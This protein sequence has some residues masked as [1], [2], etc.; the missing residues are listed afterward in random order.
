MDAL[1][2]QRNFREVV[3][4]LPDGVVIT[5][6]RGVIQYVNRA[7]LGLFGRTSRSL[8]GKDFGFPMVSGDTTE[9]DILKQGSAAIVVEM[10]IVNISWRGESALLATLR[11][12]SKRILLSRELKRSNKDLEEFAHVI[13]HDLKAPLRTLKLLSTW[14]HDDNRQVLTREASDDLKL[15]RKTTIRMQK[16]VDDLLQY[17]K[18]S[19]SNKKFAMVD[20]NLVCRDALDNLGEDV[21]RT[22]ATV[23]VDKLPKISG[24]E[25][26]LIQLFQNIIYN[27]LIYSTEIPRVH[28]KCDKENYFWHVTIVDNGIGVESRY[29]K[30]VFMPFSQLNS[31]EVSDSSGIGLAT[32]QKIVSRHQGKIWLD[33]VYGVGSTMHILLPAGFNHGSD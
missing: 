7:S 10:R 22:K 9:I 32:C 31:S 28:I 19:S 8:V 1:D 3:N 29:I 33:S 25:S 24:D 17:S 13:S 16:M 2:S 6:I 11:D 30:S 4:D 20:L 26:Q 18:A 14:L 12:I 27:S 15:M 21:F 5:D 23:E